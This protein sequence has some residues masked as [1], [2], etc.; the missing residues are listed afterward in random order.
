MTFGEQFYLALVLLAF[1]I[2]GIA[3]ALVSTRTN[4]YMRA[5]LVNESAEGNRSRLS[6]AA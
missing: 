1:F 2:F 4:R 3:L 6:D 5:R